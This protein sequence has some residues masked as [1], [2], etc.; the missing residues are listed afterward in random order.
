MTTSS[1]RPD[2]EEASAIGD[3][4]TGGGLRGYGTGVVGAG[5][6]GVKGIGEG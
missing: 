4:S 2:D 5:V 1:N 6:K 3:G